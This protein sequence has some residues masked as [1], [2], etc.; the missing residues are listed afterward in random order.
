MAEIYCAGSDNSLCRF[1]CHELYY[2]NVDGVRNKPTIKRWNGATVTD[3]VAEYLD[4]LKSQ[5]FNVRITSQNS[6]TPYEGFT[7]Y[8]TYFEVS[9]ND[10]KWTMYLN[11]QSEKYVEYELDIHLD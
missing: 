10:L 8:E 7:Y 2:I 11:I 5:G 6:K 3:G 1:E 9:N 4:T